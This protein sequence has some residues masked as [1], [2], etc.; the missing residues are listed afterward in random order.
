M[1][2]WMTSG[3][4]HTDSTK[5][6]CERKR[7]RNKLRT[8]SEIQHTR[9]TSQ[10]VTLKP[11]CSANSMM[12]SLLSLVVFVASKTWWK[13]T[14]HNRWAV[15]HYIERVYF[16][17]FLFPCW[18]GVSVSQRK[19]EVLLII[20]L[21]DPEPTCVYNNT[22]NKTEV[23]GCIQDLDPVWWKSNELITINKLYDGDCVFYHETLPQN[24]EKHR[25]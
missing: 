15:I 9:I 2:S 6:T 25:Y 4:S 12:V 23:R 14:K 21:Q 24:W 8:V 11:L 20:L 16:H 1:F 10:R 22:I 17:T 7:Y 5:N 19:H 18:G 13:W 3:S